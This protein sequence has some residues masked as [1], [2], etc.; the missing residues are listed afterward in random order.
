VVEELRHQYVLGFTPPKADGKMHDVSID[1]KGS[2]M[3]VRARKSYRAPGKPAG[4]R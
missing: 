2:G 3:T 4:T 1:V